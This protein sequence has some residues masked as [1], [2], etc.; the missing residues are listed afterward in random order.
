MADLRLSSDRFNIRPAK[1]EDV[2]A[3]TD[4]YYHSEA[5][6]CRGATQHPN[7][8]SMLQV[9][10]ALPSLPTST[11]ILPICGRGSMTP[12][13]WDSIVRILRKFHK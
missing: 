11:P 8:I 2:E 7:L 3:I 13:A 10:S 4:V 5:L 9:S 6:D 1:K 12:G